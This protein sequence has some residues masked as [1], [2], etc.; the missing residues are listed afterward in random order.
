M[1]HFRPPLPN[2]LEL[3][4]DFYVLTSFVGQSLLVDQFCQDLKFGVFMH[5]NSI[6]LKGVSSYKG[7]GQRKAVTGFET[8]G[9][10]QDGFIY[11]PEKSGGKL[12][13]KSITPAGYIFWLLLEGNVI[14]FQKD[15]ERDQNLALP[16]ESFHTVSP[17]FVL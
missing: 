15:K 16:Q 13:H 9:G 17:F 2:P 12:F 5:Q 10:E 1:R 3:S 4:G 7:I 8:S 6:M 11:I 14:C